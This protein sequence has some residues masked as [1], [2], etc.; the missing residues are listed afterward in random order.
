MSLDYN[1]ILE[2]LRERV[3][4]SIKDMFICV[5]N[6]INIIR[7]RVK[8]FNIFSISIFLSMIIDIFDLNIAKIENEIDERV[9]SQLFDFAIDD[10]RHQF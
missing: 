1:H 2:S 4:V 8:E 7:R 5:D 6:E 9:C 10:L 3:D